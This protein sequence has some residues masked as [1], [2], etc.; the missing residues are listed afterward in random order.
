MIVESV[1]GPPQLHP[2]V[3]L[4]TVLV[5]QVLELLSAARVERDIALAT[6]KAATIHIETVPTFSR[7]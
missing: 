2:N 6:L 3:E 5:Q 1:I 4:T 7:V